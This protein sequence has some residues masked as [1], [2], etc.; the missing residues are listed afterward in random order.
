M[1]KDDRVET[2]HVA[3]KLRFALSLEDTW[4]RSSEEIARFI[5][6]EKQ[7]W[8]LGIIAV[9]GVIPSFNGIAILARANSVEGEIL[10]I[11][12]LVLWLFAVVMSTIRFIVEVVNTRR[13][14]KMAGTDNL[15]LIHLLADEHPLAPRLA[16]SHQTYPSTVEHF[17]PEMLRMWDLSE[18]VQGAGGDDIRDSLVVLAGNVPGSAAG[19]VAAEQGL[20][21]LRQDS[22]DLIR[23]QQ[24]P[25]R[26]RI[27]AEKETQEKERRLVAQAD[28]DHVAGMFTD[29]SRHVT[30]EREEGYLRGD[31]IA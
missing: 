23:L 12:A 24:E 22:E 30:K 4:A 2:A 7:P 19:A 26:Q 31:D 17:L 21:K 28:A 18:Q 5:P 11:I 16:R 1:S 8:I 3:K 13:V 14:P 27:R 20:R 25:E 10:G 29:L 15:Q 6:A 9:I